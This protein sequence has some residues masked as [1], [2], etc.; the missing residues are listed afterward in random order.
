MDIPGF[1]GPVL[2]PEDSGYEEA[3]AIWNGA[4]DR[5]PRYIARCTGSADVRAA[6]RFARDQDIAVS[7]RG[8][9]HGV[10]GAA[11]CDDGLVIDLAP[12]KGI[13]V[14]PG[15][16]TA[17][18]QAG[19]LFGELDHETQAFG[20]ATTGGIVSHTGIAG[21]TLGGGIGWLMRRH[22]LTVDSLLSAAVVSAEG[23]L[24]AASEDEDPDLLWGL[25]GGGGNFGVVTSFE[26]RLHPVGPGVLCGP[27]L[28]D[29]EDAPAVLRNYREFVAEAPRELTTI[30][31]LAKIPPLP[32]I[33]EELHGRL[34][35]QIAM[36]YAGDPG[37]G[38]RSLAPLRRFGSPLLDLVDVRPYT[39]LQSLN[40][41]TVQHGW[42]YYWKSTDI[43]PL[44][45]PVIDILVEHTAQIGSPR[46]YTLVFQLG[47]AVTDVGED[48]TA[49]SHRNA[50]HNINI[51]AVWL[52]DEPLAESET[53]WTRR[54]F[55]ALEPHQAGVYVNFLGDEGEDRVQA[56]YGEKKYRRLV[57]L[58]DR[59]DPENFFRLNQNIPPSRG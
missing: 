35:C 57:T 44:E 52:P 47:G 37:A 58:K 3:R 11:M 34:A 55:S 54:F 23:E 13:W 28:W 14:D 21:L 32:V 45:D 39:V 26:Y 17:R 59:Y 4:I 33:P 31:R 25:R 5:R 51:N 40:D 19:V 6:V 36:C 41:P 27:V 24:L 16:L 8:G 38:E 30:V 29:L 12:M 20:L 53:G 48:D 56:A 7:V 2:T 18:A 46:S 42:H 9:G 15:G 43:G 22:G 10:S 1:A 50:T 49:Y